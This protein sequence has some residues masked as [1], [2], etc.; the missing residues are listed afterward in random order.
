MFAKSSQMHRHS[1]LRVNSRKA[2]IKAKTV[3]KME[4]F[5]LDINMR[6]YLIGDKKLLS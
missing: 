3:L 4:A 2:L 1:D 6:W 5:D